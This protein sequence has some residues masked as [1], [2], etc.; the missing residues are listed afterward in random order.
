MSKQGNKEIM[1]YVTQVLAERD[2][3]IRQAFGQLSQQ[4]G[5]S[6]NAI[7][8]KTNVI[9]GALKELGISQELIEK[10]S[11]EIQQAM[12]EAQQKE[13]E[14]N[15]PYSNQSA[16]EGISDAGEQEDIEGEHGDEH[17]GDSK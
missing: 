4:I 5:Q 16:K 2:E 12:A 10:I 3:G 11:K 9:F 17:F 14:A 1:E 6:F 8:F 7:D 15:E 13:G